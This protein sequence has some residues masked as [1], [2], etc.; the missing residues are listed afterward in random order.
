MSDKREFDIALSFAGEDRGYVDQVANLLRDSG[1]KV[2]YDKFEED[3]LWGKNLYDYLSDIYMN[4]ALYTIMFVSE[5]YAKKLW[6]SH[7]RKAMQAR[8]FQESQEYILPARFDDT[9]ISG[10]LP[11]T[12]YISLIER[13]PEK[14]VEVIRKKLIN[15]G[16]TLPSES[17]R[18]ALF[19]TTT[20]P[21]LDP[22]MPSVSVISSS[23]ATVASAT[24]VA[25]AD[26]DTTK[27][28]HTDTNGKVTLTIPTRRQYQLLV[29]HPDFPAAL[30]SSWDPA[31][32]IQITLAVT[33]NTGSVICHGTGYIPGLEGRLNPILDTSN[34]TYLYADNIAINSGENQ[35]AT[36]KVGE[37][38][39][40]EDSNGVIMEV[41]VIYIKGRT[42]LIQF[43]R[44]RY[45]R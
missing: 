37:P 4:K 39:E 33:E 16:R 40:L 31:E 1:V 28:G 12:G 45:D 43:V 21:R 35:P 13:S 15:N 41:R 22:Q 23:G 10:I 34:R 11:T 3:N 6:T 8:A 36:F 44:P 17:I 26:N 24:V 14:F 2:F 5:H 9:E 19:A 20:I 7:E 32:D 18:K 25:I 29:A 42:S 27:S 38:F 30:I